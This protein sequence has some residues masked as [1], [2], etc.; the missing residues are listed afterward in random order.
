MLCFSDTETS[1]LFSLKIPLLSSTSQ[2]GSGQP[3]S[4]ST[5]SKQSDLVPTSST[6][7][8]NRPPTDCAATTTTNP[9]MLTDEEIDGMVEALLQ[10]TPSVAPPSGA[11]VVS[12][13][14]DDDLKEVLGLDIGDFLV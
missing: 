4:V 7:Y 11:V 3:S 1:P 14:I 5:G 12:P 9:F 13:D 2:I 8:G 10:A 6:A